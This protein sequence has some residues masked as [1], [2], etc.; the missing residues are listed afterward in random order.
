MDGLGRSGDRIGGF[1]GLVPSVVAEA[2][3]ETC[4]RHSLTLT[5][6]DSNRLGQRYYYC[7]QFAC[8][9]VTID[10]IERAFFISV[11]NIAGMAENRRNGPA[12]SLDSGLRVFAPGVRADYSG[13]NPGDASALRNDLSVK[14]GLLERYFPQTLDGDFSAV[15]DGALH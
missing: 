5:E 11:V 6:S 12:L 4:A 2:T 14:L 10:R 3:A 13:V 9:Q 8:L 15:P 1:L 7:N